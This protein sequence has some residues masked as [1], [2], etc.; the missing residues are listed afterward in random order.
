MVPRNPKP[1]EPWRKW[2]GGPDDYAFVGDFFEKYHPYCLHH[3]A[4]CFD[5]ESS[6]GYTIVNSSGKVVPTRVLGE[7]YLRTLY[8]TIPAPIDWIKCIRPLSWMVRT[9]KI[10]SYLK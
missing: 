10:E 7:E 9:K 6:V 2:G 1:F 8:G 5:L 3:S 4:G